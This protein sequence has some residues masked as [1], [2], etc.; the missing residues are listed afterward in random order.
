MPNWVGALEVEFSSLFGKDCTCHHGL[1]ELSD[2][3]T[4]W[5][6]ASITNYCWFFAGYDTEV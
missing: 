2:I 3:G 6:P 1:H 4:H 5:Q